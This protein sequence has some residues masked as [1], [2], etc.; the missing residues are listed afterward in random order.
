MV[1]RA[2]T[3]VVLL[4]LCATDV[5]AQRGLRPNRTSGSIAG[6]II[7]SDGAAAEGAR[8]AVYSDDRK[9]SASPFA[10]LPMVLAVAGATSRRSMFEAIEMCSMSA[11][12]PGFH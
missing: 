4:V 7:H 12:A 3:L 10:N 11:F 8:V 5:R 6:R 9:S 2:V 1:F